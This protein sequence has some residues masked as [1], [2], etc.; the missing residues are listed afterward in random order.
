MMLKGASIITTLIFSKHLLDMVIQIRHIVGCGLS[1][2]GLCL[3]G[4]AE[5][6]IPSADQEQQV[7]I[8]LYRAATLSDTL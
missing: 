6:Y 2:L 1:V 7:L 8:H 5:V 3:V 4:L